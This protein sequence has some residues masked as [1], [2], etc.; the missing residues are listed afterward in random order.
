MSYLSYF[1]LF[2][3]LG[4]GFSDGSWGRCTLGATL[5]RGKTPAS[6]CND[7]ELGIA[8]QLEALGQSLPLKDIHSHSKIY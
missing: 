2:L 6:R 5:G 1:Y 3:M 8:L 7:S 4:F